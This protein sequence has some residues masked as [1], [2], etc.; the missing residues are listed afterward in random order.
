MS[1]ITHPSSAEYTVEGDAAVI[2]ADNGGVRSVS[3][4]ITLSTKALGADTFIKL[5]ENF[6]FSTPT[7][8]GSAVI[9]REEVASI[10]REQAIAIAK[11]TVAEFREAV[12][13]TPRGNTSVHPVQPASNPGTAAGTVAPS[14]GAAATVAVANGA[15]A[16]AAGGIEWRSV[17]NKFGDGELRFIT[18]ASFPTARLESE[19]GQWLAGRGLNPDAFKVWD[20]RTGAKGLEAGVSAG[21]VAAVKVSKEASEYVSGDVTGIAIARVKFNSDGSV[22]VYWTKEGESALKFGAL[23]RIKLEA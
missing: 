8:E 9:K 17:P 1:N 23:D 5:E 6:E 14:F 12:A 2:P 21:C 4:S 16:P 22:Y 15:A 11:E 20:N 18:S 19:V 13:A 3:V 7:D 10:L